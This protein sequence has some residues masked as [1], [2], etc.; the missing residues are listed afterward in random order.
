VTYLGLAVLPR[1][2]LESTL[3]QSPLQ[4]PSGRGEFCIVQPANSMLWLSPVNRFCVLDVEKSNTSTCKPIAILLL[5][6]SAATL[7]TQKPKWEKKLPKQLSVSTLDTHRTSL[8]LT[9]ELCTIDTSKVHSIKALL[10]CRTTGSF[11]DRDFVCNKGINIQSILHLISIF[12]VNGTPSKARQI[13]E[14]VDVVLLSQA[15]FGP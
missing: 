1:I 13:S 5:S 12:N 14:V 2:L 9:I 3:L 8:I 6:F 11:I 4:E 10:D 15:S 7:V